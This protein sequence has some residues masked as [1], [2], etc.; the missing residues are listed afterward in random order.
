MVAFMKKHIIIAVCV[1]LLL[2]LGVFHQE[3]ND[4]SHISFN[5]GKNIKETAKASGAPRW[6]TS[7]VA[8]Y[9][10]YELVNLP[11]NIQAMYQRPGYEIAVA[12]LFALTLYADK[13]N[14]NNLAV[15]AA[16]LQF[17][18]KAVKS[19]SSAK[20]FVESIIA[21][22]QKGKW[23]RHIDALCPAVTGKSSY[24]NET[25]ELERIGFCPLDP[26]YQLP[27]ADW[28]ALMAMT[29]N[30]QW[31]GD[32]VLATLTTG[33]SDDVRGITYSIDLEFE[34]I[35]VKSRRNEETRQR[36]IAEGGIA[37]SKRL[38]EKKK[39][40]LARQ[41]RIKILEDNARKRGD[42]VVQR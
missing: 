7:D 40:E 30:Y 39:S 12:P 42:T 2:L 22:F 34:D 4:M 20:M 35:A 19:H 11:L 8:G 10:S 23:Q 21:Q 15:E 33:F 27:E 3:T 28:V 38:D 14:N 16:T 6:G 13:N 9:I 26:A 24:M 18:A 31:E 25:G 1:G 36:A 17:S 32:G 29:Q 41:E 37:E 5:L